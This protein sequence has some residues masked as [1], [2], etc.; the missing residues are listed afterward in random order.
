MARNIDLYIDKGASFSQSI[1][2]KDQQ[3]VILDLL[4]Y[5]VQAQMAKSYYTRLHNQI[6]LN[7][8]IADAA[9]GV[10]IL[11][12][13]V[14]ETETIRSGR[15]VYQLELVNSDGDITRVADGIVTVNPRA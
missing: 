14:E 8:M 5:S 2:I 7:A 4:G 12:L 1:T 13:S 9:A 3:G 6:T 11:E 10:I 15:Y